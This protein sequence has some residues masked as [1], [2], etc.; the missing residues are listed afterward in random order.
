MEEWFDERTPIGELA[1][2]ILVKRIITG[3]KLSF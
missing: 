3:N 2:G 1:N